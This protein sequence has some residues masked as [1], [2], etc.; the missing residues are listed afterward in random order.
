MK[1]FNELL[2]GLFVLGMVGCASNGPA[3]LPPQTGLGAGEAN[4]LIDAYKMDVGDMVQ[5]TVWK[6]PDLSV[7]EPIRPDGMVA[8]PLVG[9]IMAAGLG[10]EQLAAN[11]EKKLSN[12]VKNPNVTVILTSLEGHQ[13]LSRVRVTGS[14][15]AQYRH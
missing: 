6:N 5:I 7:A 2:I 10:P 15:G 12:Y 1:F 13:F 8:V 3:N 9:D 4:V 14:V 11:I